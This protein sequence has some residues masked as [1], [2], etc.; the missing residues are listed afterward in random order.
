MQV[1]AP[2]TTASDDEIK[3]FYTCLEDTID[4]IPNREIAIIMGDFNAKIG[5]TTNDDHLRTMI[6]QYGIGTRNVRG[7]RLL[8]FCIDNNFTIANSLFKQHIRRLYTWTSPDQ[9]TK[10]QIDYI[11]IRSRWRTSILS[12]KTLPGADCSTDHR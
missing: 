9:R 2:T 4:K 12:T 11:M 10:N 3:D 6:S 7:E 1:Y 5:T 8:Q